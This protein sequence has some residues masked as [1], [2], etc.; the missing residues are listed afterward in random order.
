MPFLFVCSFCKLVAAVAP[1]GL[2]VCCR[3][4]WLLASGAV[5]GIWDA[6]IPGCLNTFPSISGA[7]VAALK[8]L[9]PSISFI[10]T[11]K[12]DFVLAPGI[13]FLYLQFLF[14]VLGC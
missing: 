14:C 10:P 2:G 11:Q 13:S 1:A 6:S 8:D 3:S 5:P 4:V 9:N 12:F 7:G